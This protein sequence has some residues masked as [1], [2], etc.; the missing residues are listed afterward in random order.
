MKKVI[1]ML[2]GLVLLGSPVTAQRIPVEVWYKMISAEYGKS[3]WDSGTRTF[4]PFS[5]LEKFQFS[6]K[7]LVSKERVKV[8]L[9][10]RCWTII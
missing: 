6:E 4:T 10:E 2:R 3:W 5:G 9:V 7:V 8:N 1:T